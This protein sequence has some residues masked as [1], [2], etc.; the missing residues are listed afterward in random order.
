M[1]QIPLTL[2]SRDEVQEVIK[3]AATKLYAIAKAAYGPGS[4]NVGLGFTHGAPLLSHD[5][6]SNMRCL[7]LDDP[8]EDD[9]VQ[10]IFQVSQKNNFKVGDGTTAVVILTYH[11]LMAAQRME[12]KGA[13]ISDIVAKLKEAEKIALA[14][15]EGLVKP[16]G[17]DKMLEYVA[18]VSAG[19]PEIGQKIAEVMKQIGQDGGVQ[20][21]QSESG[22]ITYEVVDGFYFHKGYTDT[23]LINDPANNQSNHLELPILV[24]SKSFDTE[25]DIAPVLEKMVNAG[26]KEVAVIAEFK[27]A[28]LEV[29]K[30]SKA[31]GIIL[32]VPIE[33]PFVAGSQTLFLDDIALM[34]GSRVYTGTDFEPENHLGF[35]KEGLVTEWSTAI[36]GGEGDAEQIEARIELLRNQL[37]EESHPNTI[38]FIKDRLARLTCKMSIIKV[39]GDTEFE[40]DEIKLRVQD[41]VSAVQSAMKGGIL[42]GGGVVL[43]RVSG[44]EFDDAFKEPFKQLVTNCG[45]NPEAL[46]AKLGDDDWQ[47]FNLRD[48]TGRVDML[49]EGIIDPALVVQEI[50]SNSI[51]MV[52]NLI[53]MNAQIAYKDKD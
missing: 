13:S 53:T 49:K 48:F 3:Q 15:V 17:D 37:L 51:S 21:E 34:V 20:I 19:D 33:P 25:V 26:F 41:A 38:Q 45:L 35:A 24:S 6:V 52:S 31:R 16:I 50:I 8:F 27:P 23:F 5:G 11:L 1:R 9:I 39:G 14:Y 47:G 32:V 28:A 46:L 36:I 29:L 44:T 22:D 18:T 2:T 7:R 42:P 30:M 43:A 12:G 4:G 10:A 40:R